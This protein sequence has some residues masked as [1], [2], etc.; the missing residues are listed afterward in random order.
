MATT[1]SLRRRGGDSRRETFHGEGVITLGRAPENDVVLLCPRVSKRHA[2]L[3]LRDGQLWLRDLTS[4]NGT[5]VNGV[6]LRAPAAL[7]PD[8]I[9][10]IGDFT[11]TVELGR[12][13]PDP[14]RHP[15]DLDEP[16]S[17]G[18]AL[19]DAGGGPGGDGVGE[20]EA[21]PRERELAEELTRR[22]AAQGLR[23]DA[24]LRVIDAMVDV[25]ARGSTSAGRH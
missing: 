8:D 4:K 10:Q 6:P 21:I 3:Q 23:R 24:M 25:V 2:T 15:A 14:A 17:A 20:P 11:L 22:L 5:V 9:L 12:T 7:G 13:R 16:T 1:I 19:G 18:R